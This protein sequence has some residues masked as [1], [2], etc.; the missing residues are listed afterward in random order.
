MAG[1]L[2]VLAQV[3]EHE[4]DEKRA[5]GLFKKAVALSPRD[6]P[7][8]V[9]LLEYSL[10]NRQAKPAAVHMDA[11]LRVAPELAN[12]LLPQA[13]ALAVNPAAQDAMLGQL[14]LNPPWRRHLLMALAIQRIFR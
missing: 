8:H 13:A 11:L 6:L 1:A 4:G 12:V 9:W 5:A 2:R 10:R 14:A 3:A 7:S